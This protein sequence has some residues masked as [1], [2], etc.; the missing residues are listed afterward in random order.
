M[1][2]IINRGSVICNLHKNSQAAI[3]CIV[4]LCVSCFLLETCYDKPRVANLA[5]PF[6][7][8]IVYEAFLEITRNEPAPVS[9][10]SLTK[11][12]LYMFVNLNV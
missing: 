10:S 4:T 8:E 11:L 9:N 5:C 2:E 7:H 12:H 3:N 6:L 1:Y